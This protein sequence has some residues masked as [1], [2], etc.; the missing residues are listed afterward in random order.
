LAKRVLVFSKA[1]ED[2]IPS[3]GYGHFD[4]ETVAAKIYICMIAIDLKLTEKKNIRE[5]GENGHIEVD[6]CL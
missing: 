2:N 3:H 4:F 5:K 1:C 6:W